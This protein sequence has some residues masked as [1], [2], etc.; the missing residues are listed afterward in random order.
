MKT[1]PDEDGDTSFPEEMAKREEREMVYRTHMRNKQ[2][3]AHGWL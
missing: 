3:P 2:Q 1:F